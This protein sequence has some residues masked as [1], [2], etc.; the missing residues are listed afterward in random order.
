LNLPAVPAGGQGI[1]N[2]IND[3]ERNSLAVFE[4]RLVIDF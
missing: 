2:P 4:A 1:F 3:V